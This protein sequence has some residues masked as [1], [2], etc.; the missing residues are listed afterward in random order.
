[1][2]LCQLKGKLSIDEENRR[3][4]KQYSPLCCSDICQR[5]LSVQRSEQFSQEHSSRKTVSFEDEIMSKDRYPR[6]FSRQ[7]EATVFIILQIFF[8]TGTALKIGEYHS[9]K[10]C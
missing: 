2:L 9:E 4:N 8:A 5:I 1:M 3:I 6:Q 10:Q 7:M